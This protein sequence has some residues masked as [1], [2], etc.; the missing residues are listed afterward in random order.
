MLNKPENPALEKVATITA[1]SSKKRD[2]T[3]ERNDLTEYIKDEG[4]P[5]EISYDHCFKH[6]LCYIVMSS[7]KS[8]KCASCTKKGIKYVNLTWTALNK[9]R[10]QTKE[11]IDKDLEVM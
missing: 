7:P 9:T 3:A 11:Q 4:D 10:Q 5:S 8:L 1:R 2:R 6:N